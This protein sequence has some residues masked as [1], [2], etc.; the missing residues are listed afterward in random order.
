MEETRPVGN[1]KS[2]ENIALADDYLDVLYVYRKDGISQGKR[3]LRELNA[4]SK[5]ANHNVQL[6]RFLIK[7]LLIRIHHHDSPDVSTAL[8]DFSEDIQLITWMSRYAPQVSVDEQEKVSVDHVTATFLK[9]AAN[10]S[11]KES[12]LVPDYIFHL[13]SPDEST[14]HVQRKV[15]NST[16]WMHQQEVPA[17][18]LEAAEEMAKYI[19]HHGFDGLIWLHGQVR[20]TSA[21]EAV[22]ISLI[23]TQLEHYFRRNDYHFQNLRNS[24]GYVPIDALIRFRRMKALKATV[25]DVKAAAQK[26]AVLHFSSESLCDSQPSWQLIEKPDSSPESAQPP[27]PNHFTST[28]YFGVQFDLEKCD[29][30]FCKEE[31]IAPSM[32]VLK[33][34]Y[35]YDSTAEMAHG[36]WELLFHGN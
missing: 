18:G 33:L 3:R 12:A 22:R 31:H 16:W 17:M 35:Y 20:Y 13:L 15:W 26:S 4:T 14:G 30:L 7:H 27:P 10:S 36:S 25:E 19:T 5:I 11:E 32:L 8:E 9:H 28:L 29:I 6:L 1:S 21:N 34:V 24:Q 23:K 2:P